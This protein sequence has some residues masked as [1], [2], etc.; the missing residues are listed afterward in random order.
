MKVVSGSVRGSRGGGRGASRGGGRRGGGE[1]PNTRG[2]S[3]R[4]GRPPF[5]RRDGDEETHERR[6]RVRD[7][8]DGRFASRF[9]DPRFSESLANASRTRQAAT[10]SDDPRFAHVLGEK[11]DDT[12]SDDGGSQAAEDE[13]ENEELEEP[14]DPQEL[15]ALD[16]DAADWSGSEV[17]L[18]EARRRV[19]IVNCDWDHVRAVDLYAILFHALPLGGQLH[20]VS[21]FMSEYG[22]KMIPYEREHGPDL[23]VRP[24]EEG[25]AQAKQAAEK[26]R[27][28]AAEETMDD[29]EN[30]DDDGWIN[31][32]FKMI[33]EEGED[34]EKFSTGKYRKY[35]RDRMKYYYAVATFD[36]PETA[37]HV[38]GEVDGMD[39]EASGV[40]L[41]LR[42]VDDEELFEEPVSSADKV[43]PNFKPLSAFKVAALTQSR[44]KISW[45]QD[46]VFRHYSLRDSFTENTAESDLAAY[47]A[48]QSDSDDG[49][50]EKRQREK[51]RIRRKYAALLSEIG[52]SE[53]ANEDEVTGNDDSDDESSDFNPVANADDALSASDGSME[54]HLDLDAA[55]KADHLQH[56]ARQ[57]RKL[58]DAD[59][60]ER[61]KIR[62][63]ERRNAA[64]K[65]KK[66]LLRN[67]RES[68]KAALSQKAAED[69]AQLRKALQGVALPELEAT[70]GKM[71]KKL[72]AQLKKSQAAQEREQRKKS[73]L[74][75]SLGISHLHAV[76]EKNP[77]GEVVGIDD[78]FK[79]K[80]LHD[81]RFHLEVAQRD[82]KT[83]APV[84]SLA[85]Q[86]VQQRRAPGERNVAQ[87]KSEKTHRDSSDDAVG[88]FMS[89]PGK[90]SRKE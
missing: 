34:G 46:D 68:E 82:K 77:A 19:A 12:D 23:W 72:H 7:R 67:E 28:A 65:T 80:L 51:Q 13:E 3:D 48:P 40:V 6:G 17:D 5:H 25:Y 4:G 22:K 10:A 30:I 58:A 18:C 43:P 60:G 78:R 11:S 56:G 75:S 83:K 45:D 85:A 27:A 89:R 21:V 50:D 76:P 8:H 88:Y 69:K 55:T 62:Y 57:R 38:Y 63:K 14:L 54:A 2:L 9:T 44:F 64:K 59:V 81:P 36:S 71:K 20:N 41:D 70:S 84:Q 42:Y 53:E 52:V 61:Q 86:V 26:D 31:D 47:I 73:R 32:N 66:E 37:A 79:Q 1:S 16:E 33:D 39:V 90:K 49:D 74:A 29:D 35:E 15:A 87:S 24:D